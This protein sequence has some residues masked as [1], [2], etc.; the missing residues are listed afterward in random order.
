LYEFLLEGALLGR[1]MCGGGV[2]VSLKNDFVLLSTSVYL[3]KASP[4]QLRTITPTFI[5]TLVKWRNQVREV[6]ADDGASG[7]F[8]TASQATGGL[9]ASA[10]A[11]NATPA[12]YSYSQSRTMAPPPHAGD[13]F[14]PGASQQRV[15]ATMST[16]FIPEDNFDESAGMSSSAAANRRQEGPLVGIEVT[17]SDSGVPGV[18]VLKARGPAARAGILPNDV[19]RKVDG[20]TITSLREFQ[21]AVRSLRANVAT[22]FVVERART[23][24]LVNVLVGTAG[25]PA[26]QFEP[27]YGVV[28]HVAAAGVADGGSGRN[29]ARTGTSRGGSASQSM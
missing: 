26:S 21:Q 17:E 19:V 16:T 12:Q 8:T 25:S 24:L 14:H 28:Q 4:S 27:R 1:D 15:S 7:V 20:Q 13:S 3:P 11:Q 22:P 29:G 9:R 2:G 6:L 10:N 5:E 23:Q 18:I